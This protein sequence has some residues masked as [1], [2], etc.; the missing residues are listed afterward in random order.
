MNLH[1]F[2]QKIFAVWM[3][4]FFLV[5]PVLGAQV[6]HAQFSILGDVPRTRSKD[7]F[8]VHTS[9]MQAAVVRRS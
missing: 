3:A 6:A 2:A 8:E 1:R 5:T 9:T 4:L 7:A